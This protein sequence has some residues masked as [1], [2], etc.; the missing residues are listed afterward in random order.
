MRKILF[1]D[2][3]CSVKALISDLENYFDFKVTFLQ[4]YRQIDKEL[5]TKYDAVIL[6]IMM[7]LKDD[8]TYF[9][10]DE[11]EKTNYGRKT[12]IIVFEKIRM[13]YPRLPIIFYSS[14]M[15]RIYCDECTVVINKPERAKSIAET[16]NI[17]IERISNSC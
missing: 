13:Q 12:G 1:V 17:L 8:D 5:Q 4:D 14:M 10:Q 9:S 11:K 16:I 6:D 15:E 7:P 3:E 2:D